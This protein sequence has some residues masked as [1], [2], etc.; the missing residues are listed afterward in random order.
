MTFFKR[1]IFVSEFPFSIN[2]VQYA[3]HCVKH[4]DL[5]DLSNSHL[6]HLWSLLKKKNDMRGSS[7]VSEM[8]QENSIKKCYRWFRSF[9]LI[10]TMLF[11]FFFFIQILRNHLRVI[12]KV[13]KEE[14]EKR[15]LQAFCSIYTMI[16]NVG[17]CDSVFSCL[18]IW[19]PK[20]SSFVFSG[21]SLQSPFSLLQEWACGAPER[22]SKT[23]WRLL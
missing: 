16:M 21:S 1:L 14:G 20:L 23:I 22:N 9:W 18:N 4:L 13:S 8:I 10:P 12:L 5:P 7:V 6:N 2:Q 15:A 19:S 11:N 3:K 17:G